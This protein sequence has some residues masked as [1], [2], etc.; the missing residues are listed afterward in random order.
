MDMEQQQQQTAAE[1]LQK[2]TD[3]MTPA[4]V[5]FLKKLEEADKPS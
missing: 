5:N 3:I 1:Y 4:N 2:Q